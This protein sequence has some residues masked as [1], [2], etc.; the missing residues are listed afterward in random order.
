MTMDRVSSRKHCELFPTTFMGTK[1]VA[2][3][4]KDILL[5]AAA[6]KGNDRLSLLSLTR[7][8][9]HT[10][11]LLVKFS[12]SPYD[13]EDLKYMLKVVKEV[14]GGGPLHCLG[15]ALSSLA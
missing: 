3:D 12:T 4:L 6:G 8:F 7:T 10:D 5:Q 1:R 14:E 9:V 13:K 11:R 2:G 15:V